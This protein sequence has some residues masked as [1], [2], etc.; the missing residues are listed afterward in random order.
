[1]RFSKQKTLP[2]ICL[3]ILCMLIPAENPLAG[4][5]KQKVHAHWLFAS[6][7]SRVTRYFRS[8][9][10]LAYSYRVPSSWRTTPYLRKSCLATPV[11]T[12]IWPARKERQNFHPIN[13]LSRDGSDSI[14]KTLLE[15]FSL[16]VTPMESRK[17]VGPWDRR[18][19]KLVFLIREGNLPMETKLIAKQ[20]MN[21]TQWHHVVVNAKADHFEL[22]MDGQLA[23]RQDRLEST[24]PYPDT[25]HYEIG[26]WKVDAQR[27][28][29][30][31]AIHELYLLNQPATAKEIAT[32]FNEKNGYFPPPGPEPKRLAI[33][34]GPFVDWTSRSSVQISW[35]MDFETFTHIDLLGPEGEF[36]EFRA[37]SAT[38]KH[39]VHFD[40]LKPDAEYRFR[41]HG[42]SEGD[43]AQFSRLYTFDSSFH[44]A[45][46]E[47]REAPEA[48]SVAISDKSIGQ[49]VDSFAL[50]RC[51]QGL[52]S[53]NRH[54]RKPVGPR[55]CL[56]CQ[57]TESDH[58]RQLSHQ[59]TR[60]QDKTR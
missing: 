35:N 15:G 26:N 7:E 52:R 51:R 32:R 10:G 46:I 24:I 14:P 48:P 47:L 17:V 11:A 1:M 37:A 5:D 53:A 44:Y 41:I 55:V 25:L 4:P 9:E 12:F 16:P 39:Q 60:G 49:S 20:A 40:E 18:K 59:H 58:G 54:F 22:W 43:H 6:T 38:K 36:R 45:P 56:G 31:G 27:Q 50:Y 21:V 19:G 29:M 30:E 3:L 23:S 34:Y 28:P 13:L 57:R 8:K 33:G 42:P 2:L